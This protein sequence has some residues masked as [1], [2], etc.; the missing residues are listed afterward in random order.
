MEINLCSYIWMKLLSTISGFSQFI[1]FSAI[2]FGISCTSRNTSVQENNSETPTLPKSIEPVKDS[3][4]NTTND[5]LTHLLEDTSHQFI[6]LTWDDGPQPPGTGNCRNLFKELGV[7]ASFFAVGFN[8][9]NKDR[10]KLM[11]SIR[12][13]Y[14]ALLLVNHGFSHAMNNHY[15]RFYSPASVDTALNDFLHNERLMQ[16]EQKIIR[17]PGHNTWAVNG[18]IG[19]QLTKKPLVHRLDSMGYQVIGWDTEWRGSSKTHLPAETATEMA[20]RVFELLSSGKTRV[21]GTVVVLSHD[22]YFAHTDAVDS[23]RR[24]IQLLQTNPRLHFETIEKY[25]ELHRIRKLDGRINQEN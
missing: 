22:R 21:P 10:E 7:K 18:K 13:D 16:I 25:R 11:D 19:G 12:N 3:V 5:S 8:I 20:N 2:S 17:F 24:F 14:P 6:F 9:L 4:K 23:L 1:L 15:Q